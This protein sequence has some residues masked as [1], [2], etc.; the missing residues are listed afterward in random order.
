MP[1]LRGPGQWKRRLL[2]LVVESQ[3]LY[4]APVWSAAVTASA[5]STAALLRPQRLVALRVIRAYRTVLDEAAF[6]LALMPPADLL[7]QERTRMRTHRT[8]PLP[9]GAPPTD[10]VA[11]RTEE[12]EGTLDLWQRR[13]LF[14]PKAQWT[15][16]L[17]P[18]VRRWVRRPLPKIPLTYRMTQ[19]LTGH[20]CFQHYL[21]RMGRAG[22][23]MCGSAVDTAEHTLLDCEYWEPFRGELSE[24]LGQR[25]SVRALSL[26][27]CGP[28]EEDLPPDPLARSEAIDFATES[29]RLLYRMVEG[30]L[31]T[32]EEEERVRQAAEPAI[33]NM[34]P[35][36][37]RP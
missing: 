13:W 33:R 23:S 5:K 6:A 22:S 11:L 4:A 8:Q 1:N 3:L 10:L 36:G 16:R 31:S 18:D 19:S 35:G 12:R 21:N 7:A 20:G 17:I 9:P 27:I 26:T 14:S 25:L 34:P 24:R 2:S 30:L 29:L 28:L 37:D 32:K 15:R